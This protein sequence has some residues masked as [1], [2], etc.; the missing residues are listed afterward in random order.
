MNNASSPVPQ[1]PGYAAEGEPY[2][3]DQRVLGIPPV[4]W[5]N[6]P[7]GYGQGQGFAQAQAYPS[8]SSRPSTQ[9]QQI[10]TYGQV[11]HQ[12]AYPPQVPGT[13]GPQFEHPSQIDTYGLPQYSV[14]PSHVAASQHSFMAGT[15]T[16]PFSNVVGEGQTVSPQALQRRGT[17]S[18]GAHHREWNE[19]S[20]TGF[21][22]QVDTSQAYPQVSDEGKQ[23]TYPLLNHPALSKISHQG[24]GAGPD[25]EVGKIS[26]SKKGRPRPNFKI[27]PNLPKKTENN[28]SMGIQDYPYICCIVEPCV[29]VGTKGELNI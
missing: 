18:P 1:G 4:A 20:T 16:F 2:V 9:A 13:Y 28:L 8:Q 11:Q 27:E 22:N 7:T 29:L 3:I 19:G 21:T 26:V 25:G 12:L 24:D 14:A 17:N 5:Q 23:M 15:D 10:S 6:V